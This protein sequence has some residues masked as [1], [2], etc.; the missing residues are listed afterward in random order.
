M[1]A[2][3]MDTLLSYSCTELCLYV[4]LMTGVAAGGEYIDRCIIK[5]WHV[6][7]IVQCHSQKITKLEPM[8]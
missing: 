6:L 2:W 8:T 7:S 1:V 4:C 5:I 3:C